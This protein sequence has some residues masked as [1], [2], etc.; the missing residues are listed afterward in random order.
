MPSRPHG[1]RYGRQVSDKPLTPGPTMTKPLDYSM[2]EVHLP[3][4]EDDYLQPKSSKPSY[5]V[6]TDGKGS[7]FM[8][9]SQLSVIVNFKIMATFSGDA[10]LWFCDLLNVS[11]KVLSIFP[12]NLLMS[13]FVFS[14]LKGRDNNKILVSIVCYNCSSLGLVSKTSTYR[15]TCNCLW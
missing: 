15:D 9:L 7:V 2:K 6:L 11:N 10:T 8:F 3:V 5:M 1:H 13:S 12:E 14:T 4:D